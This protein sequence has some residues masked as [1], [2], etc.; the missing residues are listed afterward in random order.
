MRKLWQLSLLTLLMLAL[1]AA[2]A[3]A[4]AHV[5]DDAGLFSA[6]EAEQVE[7]AL[8]DAEELCPGYSFF[9]LTTDDTQGLSAREYADEYY[10]V[11][12]GY[13][14]GTLFLIDMDNREIY[15]CTTAD[16]EAIFGSGDI[17]DVL[18]AAYDPISRGD[19]AG[20][21]IAYA[22]SASAI[23]HAESNSGSSSV[24]PYPPGYDYNDYYQP[25]PQNPIARFIHN[26]TGQKLLIAFGVAAAVAAIFAASTVSSYK[27]VNHSGSEYPLSSRSDLQ[28]TE[29][30]DT[31]V[32]NV[33]T[34]RVIPQNN[35]NGGGGG[36]HVSSRGISH[37]GGGRKF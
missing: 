21:A 22:E 15:L 6:S 28:L 1:F 31:L 16:A 2:P 37:G 4:L 19:Y 25:Q 10:D 34:H 36:H 13:S 30:S 11:T 23:I 3:F 8:L 9:V 14:S 33:V 17:D 5:Q 24:A 18:D 20:C 26:L 7:Q 12:W 35:N 27:S 32:G 29:Q